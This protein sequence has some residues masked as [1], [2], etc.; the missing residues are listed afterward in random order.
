MKPLTLALLASVCSFSASAETRL[1]PFMGNSETAG[2]GLG[3]FTALQTASD[4]RI[5]QF[6][7]GLSYTVGDCTDAEGVRWDCLRHLKR[8][9]PTRSYGPA[10]PYARSLETAFPSTNGY[11]TT[12]IPG[13][14]SGSRAA[15]HADTSGLDPISALVPGIGSYLS[16]MRNQVIAARLAFPSACIHS[17]GINLGHNDLNQGMSAP[18]FKATMNTLLTKWNN[19]MPPTEY[20]CNSEGVKFVIWE[21]GDNWNNT[22]GAA[23]VE[24]F[25]TSLWE[26]QGERTDVCIVRLDDGIANSP[27]DG[28]QSAEGWAAFAGRRGRQACFPN[29]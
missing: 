5:R 6:T 9:Y 15:Q 17:V 23:E 2:T 14:V 21:L 12:I 26:L 22:F 3:P 8:K 25:N 1:L 18:D 13:G 16:W 19:L 24:A 29:G 10:L 7:G 28:H 4:S 20:D 11:K 27:T